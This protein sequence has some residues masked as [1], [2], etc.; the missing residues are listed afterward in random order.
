MT[1]DEAVAL[2]DSGFWKQMTHEFYRTAG[3]AGLKIIP[4]DKCCRLLA[5][6]YVYGGGKTAFPVYLYYFQERRLTHPAQTALKMPLFEREGA[7]VAFVF[8]KR[9]NPRF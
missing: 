7:A 2:Y 3:L 5:W 1:K 4:D 8:K 6:L 9:Y